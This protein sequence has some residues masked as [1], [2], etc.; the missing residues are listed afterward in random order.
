MNFCLEFYALMKAMMNNGD[1]I[2]EDN[3]MSIK[4]KYIFKHYKYI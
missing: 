2:L 1:M 3:M 4:F